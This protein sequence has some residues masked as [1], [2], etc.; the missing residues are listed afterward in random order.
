[1]TE[2]SQTD[3]FFRGSIVESTHWMA[4]HRPVE[5]AAL[6]GQVVFQKGIV[7]EAA[8]HSEK[9]FGPDQSIREAAKR[10]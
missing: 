3:H 2:D 6:I 7:R 1:L 4:L 5:L 8:R 9:I 10:S